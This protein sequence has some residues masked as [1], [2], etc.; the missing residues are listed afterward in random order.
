[1]PLRTSFS[2]QSCSEAPEGKEKSSFKEE[3][4]ITRQLLPQ[5]PGRLPGILGCKLK[6]ETCHPSLVIVEGEVTSPAPSSQNMNYH[7]H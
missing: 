7:F 5:R 2:A 1:M 4:G 3:V 6:F